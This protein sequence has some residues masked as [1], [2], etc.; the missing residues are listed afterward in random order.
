MMLKPKSAQILSMASMVLI[1]TFVVVLV[2]TLVNFGLD[3]TFLFRFVRGWVIAFIL[4][5]PLVVVLMP[6]LQKF[7]QG[8]TQQGQK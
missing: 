8:L 1:M 3:A 7:F 2:S 5:F 6:R 4:A